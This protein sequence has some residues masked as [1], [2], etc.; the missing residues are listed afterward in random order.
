MGVGAALTIPSAQHIIVHLYRNPVQ[1]ARAIALFGAMGALGNG[2]LFCAFIMGWASAQAIAPLVISVFA[3]LSFFIW[4]AF[5]PESH[6]A[7]P[8][9]IWKY[10]NVKIL[11]AVSLVPFMWLGSIFP[12]YSWL[13]ET[14]YHWPAIK[15]GVHFL[16]IALSSPAGLAT[17][18]FLQSKFSL[19]FV[20]ILGFALLVVGTI[21]LPFGDSEDLYWRFNFPGFLI[22][23]FGVGIVYATANI[24]LLAN[25]PAEV[26]GIV[27]AMFMAM[28]QTGGAAGIGIV[29]SIQ[30]SVEARKGGPLVF[31]GRAAG[32]WFLVGFVGLLMFFSIVFMTSSK[33]SAASNEAVVSDRESTHS[34]V[35]RAEFSGD[36]KGVKMTQTSSP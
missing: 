27:S 12:V 22:S 19:K 25:T 30:A 32:L 8:P 5:I 10:E 20:N 15:T 7:L 24:G 21:L 14:V 13:W 33:P 11:T 26:S 4:E 9:K 16:P 36:T 34:S 2:Q 31:D 1:Q 3:L 18:T 29:S 35:T 6:A 28:L 17:A 23:S